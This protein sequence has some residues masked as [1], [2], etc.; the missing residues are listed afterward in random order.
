M[1]A[2]LVF[3]HAPNKLVQKAAPGV[4]S[5]WYIVAS[6]GSTYTS[7]ANLVAASKKVYPGL[8]PGMFLQGLTLK[9]EA[10]AG[11]A[12]SAFY[13]AVNPQSTPSGTGSA[14]MVLSGE[15]FTF[16]GGVWQVWVYLTTA[17]DKINMAAAY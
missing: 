7:L 15:E 9:S 13:A 11:G 17:T 5:A 12:G 14:E 8:D 1:A 6:D 16:T 3:N 4:A 10:S 2:S